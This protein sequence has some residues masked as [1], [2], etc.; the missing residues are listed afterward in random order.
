MMVPPLSMSIDIATLAYAYVKKKFN[1]NKVKEKK[2]KEKKQV[3]VLV[4]AFNEGV[5]LGFTLDSIL[6]QT[7]SARNIYI[8][9]DISTD[10]TKKVCEKLSNNHSN[11]K[12]IRRE[13]KQGK[14]GNINSLIQEKDEELGDYVLV[15][16]GDVRLK[17]DCLEELVKSLDNA[18]VITGF[19]YT[20]KPSSYI[21]KML[22]EGES[23]INS[24][25]SF[26]K[27]A[28]VIRN[29]VF[30]VCGA[31]SLYK[32]EV[33][34]KFP[35]PERT[36]T[37]DTDHTWLLQEN[38]LKILYNDKAKAEGNNPNTLIDYWKR[39][40]RWFSGTFQNLYVHGSKDLKKS[41]GL[42]YST[43]IPGVLESVPY[44]IAFSSLPVMAY[45]YPE[46]ALG[47]LTADFVL[48]LPFLHKHPKGFLHA[49]NHLPD[50]YAFKYFGSVA[51]LYSGIKTSFEKITGK[52]NSWKNN[53]TNSSRVI[54]KP[55]K[56]SKKIMEKKLNDF[57]YLERE[58]TDLGEEPWNKENFMLKKQKKW[59]LSS[60]VE[61]DDKVVGYTIV[62]EVNNHANERK[63]YLNKI[64]VDKNYQGLK[65]GLLL[66]EDMKK[67][68][69]KS[70]IEK[71]IF[72]CRTD[73][74]KANNFYLKDGCEIVDTEISPDKVERYLF[75]K[76]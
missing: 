30:V 6:E 4:P 53:W 14:A 55:R 73:N 2:N 29:G 47:L 63:A 69:K 20:K 34:Q 16:D 40:T 28:Q 32:K 36:L 64:L 48:T 37:E 17:K 57:F 54:I 62:S 12:H 51:A 23:W 52:Q 5:R 67:K 60:Y 68:C 74:E 39:Y 65:I 27:R 50:I 22:Y 75:E 1:K 15:V 66:F 43:I 58:W 26:R 70:G 11:V 44:S 7:Y 10:N 76:T 38:G 3:S 24:V 35:I 33:L 71:I 13:I 61:I 41:R 45:P 72:K 8:L 9:D 19:G 31:L 21:A 59:K 46:F 42:L 49:V 56:L 25:F 18:A